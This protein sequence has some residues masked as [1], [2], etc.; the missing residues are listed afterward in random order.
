[1]KCNMCICNRTE[2]PLRVVRLEADKNKRRRL[3]DLNFFRIIAKRQNLLF[4][5]R[6]IVFSGSLS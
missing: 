5:F 6:I 4:R 3:K 1:M 2:K